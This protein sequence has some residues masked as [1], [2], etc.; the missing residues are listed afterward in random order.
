MSTWFWFQKHL[1]KVLRISGISPKHYLSHS[2][3]IGA[4]TTAATLG[5][6][7]QTIQI[8][9]CWSS[10]A[11]H[12]H[13]NNNLTDH[14][15]AHIQLNSIKIWLFW[16][17]VNSLRVNT[18]ETDPYTKSPSMWCSIH[19]LSPSSTSNTLLIAIK[20]LDYILLCVVLASEATAKL[21]GESICN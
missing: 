14:R 15:Q 4:A 11:Y 2:F 10:Q 21:T 6:S 13:M 19:P 9:S 8:L 12:R 16:G 18:P 3:W 1:H 7:N 17:P 5:F 20:H